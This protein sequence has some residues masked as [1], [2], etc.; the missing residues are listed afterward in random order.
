MTLDIDRYGRLREKREGMELMPVT[1][2]LIKPARV[3]L[4]RHG[5]AVGYDEHSWR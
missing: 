3:Y 2:L 1:R 4:M 5:Q